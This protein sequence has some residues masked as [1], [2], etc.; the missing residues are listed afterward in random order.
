MARCWYV[1]M[2]TGSKTVAGSY[3]RLDGQKPECFSG[4]DLCAIYAPSCGEIPDAPFSTRMTNYIIASYTSTAPQPN[5][6]GAKYY[7]Y[8]VGEN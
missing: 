8:K 6:G 4:V 3:R 5:S 1:Y 2:G 7:L